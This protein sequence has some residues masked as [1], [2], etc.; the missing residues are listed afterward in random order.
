VGGVSI[1]MVGDMLAL[2][3]VGVHLDPDRGEGDLEELPPHEAHVIRVVLDVRVVGVPVLEGLADPEVAIDPVV[4]DVWVAGL[5][6]GEVLVPLG[7]HLKLVRDELPAHVLGREGL[8]DGPLVVVVEGVIFGGKIV[9]AEDEL[10]PRLDPPP[11]PFAEAD[12][13]PVVDQISILAVHRHRRDVVD[14]GLDRGQPRLVEAALLL[15]ARADAEGDDFRLEELEDLV[16]GVVHLL[17]AVDVGL[18]VEVLG[19]LGPVTSADAFV[20]REALEPREKEVDGREVGESV[21]SRRMG[22]GPRHIGGEDEVLDAVAEEDEGDVALV[23]G[24][25]DFDPGRLVEVGVGQVEG[26]DDLLGAVRDLLVVLVGAHREA[27]GPPVVGHAR[28]EV[29][30]GVDLAVV[31]GVRPA[32]EGPPLVDLRGG[33]ADATADATEEIRHVNFTGDFF[34]IRACSDSN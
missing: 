20:A 13:A 14:G 19:E 7:V 25:A 31:G 22:S 26:R 4:V 23:D 24:V 2:A 15:G 33:H 28:E 30:G 34:Y 9:E 27:L 8:G 11:P 1:D 12:R 16:A 10:V 6:L 3:R 32:R 17:V 18:V 21:A 29:A 5:E